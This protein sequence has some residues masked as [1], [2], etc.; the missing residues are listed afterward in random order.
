MVADHEGFE[1][2][3][4]IRQVGET[5]GIARVHRRRFLAEHVLAGAGGGERQVDVAVVARRD[6]NRLDARVGE[7][8]L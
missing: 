8:Y 6:V 4:A 7:Q 1:I 5:L 3:D 2:D